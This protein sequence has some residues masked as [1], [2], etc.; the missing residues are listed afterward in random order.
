M[1]VATKPITL[2]CPV[3]LAT[4]D[5]NVDAENG[6]IENIAVITAGPALGHGFLVDDVMLTQV[7]HGINTGKQGVKSRLGHP[8]FLSDGT[9]TLMG[10]V[11]NARIEKDKV[12]GDLHLGNYAAISPVGD[13]KNYMLSLAQE[14]PHAAG[15]SIS[16]IPDQFEERTDENDP[17]ANLTPLGRVKEVLAVDFVDDPAANPDGMLSQDTINNPVANAS[18]ASATPTDQEIKTMPDNTPAP[19]TPRSPESLATANGFATNQATLPAAVATPANTEVELATARQE[20]QDLGTKLERERL[21]EITGLA[22]A[23]SLNAEWQNK[24]LASNLN[25]DQVRLSALD[26]LKITNH[27]VTAAITV[28]DDR[29]LSTLAGGIS[30]GIALMAGVQIEK[31]HERASDFSNL[32]VMQAGRVYLQSMGVTDAASMAPGRLA[33][34]LL[35]TNLLH[36]EYGGIMLTQGTSDFPSILQDTVGKTLRVGY[37]TEPSTWEGIARRAESPD[38]NEIKESGEVQYV[39]LSETKETYALSEY[40]NV[41]TISRRALINDDLDAF[42]RIPQLQGAAAKRKENDVCYAVITGNQVMTEDGVALFH[43]NHG[44]LT[45]PGG[46]PTVVT[47]GAG[48]KSMRMQKA[49]KN[50]ARM[51]LTPVVLL[52]PAALETTAQ[53]LISSLVDPTKSNA[54]PNVFANKLRII[55]E[56]RLDDDSTTAWYLFA[57]TSQIDGIE[58]CFLR[59]EPAPVLTRWVDNDTEGVKYKIRHTVAARAIDHRGLYKNVGM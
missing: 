53:Q 35:N 40:G 26:Q 46:A 57:A 52:V 37:D 20:A 2:K 6:V 31:P 50:I 36:R 16:F 15:F 21:Q 5:I 10:R 27:P 8:G 1:P 12:R 24:M 47:L 28:G 33:D 39:S 9:G 17:D 18:A 25:I 14:D 13:L 4:A 30:D 41:I 3:S 29:N 42:S 44:N 45:S 7:A 19:G 56:A 51:N 34:L 11:K 23:H 43:A 58:V 38:L 55:T 48:R 54:T 49:L 32:G 59:G 22:T